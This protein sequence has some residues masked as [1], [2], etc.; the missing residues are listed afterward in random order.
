LPP[1]SSSVAVCQATSKPN[2]EEGISKEGIA[3]GKAD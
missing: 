2:V 1:Y 3:D